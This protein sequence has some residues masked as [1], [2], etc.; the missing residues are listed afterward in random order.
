MGSRTGDHSDPAGACGRRQNVLLDTSPVRSPH[1]NAMH[2]SRALVALFAA[3]TASAQAILPPFDTSYQFLNLGPIPGVGNSGG[4]AFRPGNPNE[5]VVTPYLFA[6]VRS[7]P[8]V[9]NAQGAITGFGASTQVASIGGSDGGLCFGPTG[10]LFATWYGAN[11]LSQLKPGSVAADR[12]DNL[13]ALGVSYSVGTC[14]FVPTG[15]PG[16]GRFKVIAWNTSTIHDVP[17][18]PDG[19]GTFTPGLASPGIALTGGPEGM[20]YMPTTAPLLG[21]KLLVGEW[22]AGNLVAYDIDA[23]G[24]PLPATRTLIGGGAPGFAGGALDPITGDVVFLGSSGALLI[25]RNSPACGTYTVYGPASPG[26]LGTPSI[27]GAGCARI[28]QTITIGST[29]PAFGIGIIATGFQT[30]VPYLN[31]TVLQSTSVTVVSVLN[32][33]GQGSLPLLVPLD[34][35]LGN[36]HVYFQAAYLDG[37]TSSGLI[38]SPGL[39]IL[40]R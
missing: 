6:A 5:V 8:L 24:D 20:V 38:A 15:L 11:A 28:G 34:P 33:A 18:T 2:L 17:L 14:G 39:D 7:V 36:N 30:N 9:R 27:S 12:V 3:A 35:A 29:G 21:G 26:A 10:V 31:L 22:G 1:P 25:L 16:A 37:S 4:I 23:N 32:A 19:S 40:L 13:G